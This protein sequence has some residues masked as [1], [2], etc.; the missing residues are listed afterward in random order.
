MPGLRHHPPQEVPD[1]P[2]L[3]QGW[4][5]LVASRS[6]SIGGPAQP[7]EFVVICPEA[8]TD[9]KATMTG[10]Q[11]HTYILGAPVP[12]EAEAALPP[13]ECASYGGEAGWLGMGSAV[14][15]HCSQGHCRPVFLLLQGKELADLLQSH[16]R[17]G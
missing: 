9:A 3:G 6:G 2:F 13:S 17:K 1:R 5:G 16:S 10:R 15:R 4:E 8:C 14:K 11:G 12:C 7:G